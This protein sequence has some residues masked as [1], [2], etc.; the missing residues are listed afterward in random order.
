MTCRHIIKK[1]IDKPVIFGKKKVA[2]STDKH[3]TKNQ[4]EL[5]KLHYPNRPTMVVCRLIGRSMSGV[6]SKAAGIGIYKTEQAR[7]KYGGSFKKGAQINPRGQFKP[8]QKPWNAGVKGVMKKNSGSFKKGNVPHNTVPVG[9]T[10]WIKDNA[11]GRRY[12]RVKI[13]MPN[14]WLFAHHLVWIAANGPVPDG[15]MVIF[16]DGNT[17]NLHLHNLQLIERAENMAK[18]TIQRYP[19][20]VINALIMTGRLKS[21]I[22]KYLNQKRP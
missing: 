3:Y 4:I 10:T 20:E 17:E 21:Q 5:I 15:C 7:K 13:A 18:N 8:G 9:S 14:V 16:K 11:T 1:H 19:V 6:H 2:K 22:K 12:K